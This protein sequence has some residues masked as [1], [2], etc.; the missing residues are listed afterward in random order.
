MEKVSEK[1]G[2]GEWINIL[3]DTGATGYRIQEL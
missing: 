1:V 2:D 3:K